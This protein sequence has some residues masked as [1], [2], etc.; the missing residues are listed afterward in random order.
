MLEEGQDPHNNLW[1]ETILIR[2]DSDV[3]I[4]GK[5]LEGPRMTRIS[6]GHVAILSRL[7]ILCTTQQQ[8]TLFRL[9]FVLKRY[10]GNEFTDIPGAMIISNPI[11]VFSHTVYIR[12]P[13]SMSIV[14][15]LMATHGT[16]LIPPPPPVCHTAFVTWRSSRCST[17]TD[18]CRSSTDCRTCWHA[19]APLYSRK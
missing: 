10:D 8:G 1:I 19:N 14:C 11:E 5:V 15:Q 2:S 6:N 13:K 17:S 7:K 12:R 4:P 9:K 18:S 16:L 3:A